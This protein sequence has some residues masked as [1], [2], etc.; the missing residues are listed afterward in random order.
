[1]GLTLLGLSA[2]AAAAADD[3]PRNIEL[4]PGTALSDEKTP[5]DTN[6]SE[7]KT[8]QIVT[9]P[10]AAKEAAPTDAAG[11]PDTPKEGEGASVAA[12]APP[13]E[14]ADKATPPEAAPASGK[15][16][17]AAATPPPGPYPVELKPRELALA[18]QA[19][20]KRVGCYPGSVDGVW[21]GRSREA[22]VAFGNFAKVDVAEL[23]PT[24]QTL[25]LIKGKLDILPSRKA[26]PRQCLHRVLNC[27]WRKYVLGPEAHANDPARDAAECRKPVKQSHEER[28]TRFPLHLQH[29]AD[30]EVL[31][32]HLQPLG[33][34]R[35]PFPALLH[36]RQ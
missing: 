7:G 33:H 2:E 26:L 19:E 30:D 24:P 36:F 27:L 3:L 25:A 22:L 21:G 9:E 17:E 14:P 10:A 8:R 35:R 29:I 1:M 32:D 16:A 28:R 4:K 13:A 6:A 20:L 34:A 15:P 23:A 11:K 12:P 31:N 18:V 5:T